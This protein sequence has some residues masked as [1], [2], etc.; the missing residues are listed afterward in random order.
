[1]TEAGGEPGNHGAPVPGQD[2]RFLQGIAFF[3]AGDYFEAHDEWEALWQE[4]HGADRTFLKGLI[5]AAVCLHHFGNGNVR[6]ATKLYHGSRRYLAPY[7]PVHWGVDVA[8]L[9]AQMKDGCGAFLEPSAPSGD[10]PPCPS[11][12]LHRAGQAF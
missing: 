7:L 9:L 3:N 8:S 11:I 5:Q 2:R 4:Y 1:M 6:G 12:T 10:L